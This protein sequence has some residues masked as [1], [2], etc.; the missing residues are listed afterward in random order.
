MPRPSGKHIVVQPHEN[1]FACVLNGLFN[2]PVQH[3]ANPNI[4]IEPF[5]NSAELHRA[6]LRLKML[7]RGDDMGLVVECFFFIAPFPRR[8]S[9]TRTV[10]PVSL[11]AAWAL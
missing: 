9:L 6:V 5:R 7:K 3:L 8:E 10:L 11:Q 2:V 4:L 1:V